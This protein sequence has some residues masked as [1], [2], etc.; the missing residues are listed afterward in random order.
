MYTSIIAIHFIEIMALFADYW[1][2]LQEYD[3]SSVFDFSEIDINIF[4]LNNL[5]TRVYIIYINILYFI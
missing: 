1:Y 5:Y 2:T 3:V 4:I